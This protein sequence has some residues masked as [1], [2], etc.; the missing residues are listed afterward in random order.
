IIPNPYEARTFLR[1]TDEPT[2][3]ADLIFIGRLVTEKGIDLLLE[4]LARM[5]EHALFPGLTIVGPGPERAAMEGLAGRLG[6]GET[7]TFLGPKREAELASLLVQHKIL[8]IPS[9]YDEPFGVV[10]LEGIACGCVVVGSAGG[11]LPDAIG[12]CGWTF[13]NG[14][15]DALAR[16][17][18]DLL[19]EPEA[20]RRLTAQAPAH[21]AKFQPAVVAEAYLALFR[22]QLS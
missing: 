2:R 14:D 7:V 19:R 11:G 13:P 15:I 8:V 16:A 5:R 9:R 1:P 12:P 6:L 21:L 10:A 4:A 18:E 17:L 3:P 20:R 22:S